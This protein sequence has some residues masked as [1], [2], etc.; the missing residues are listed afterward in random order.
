ML[1]P[2]RRNETRRLSRLRSCAHTRFEFTGETVTPIFPITPAGSPG[3]R[4]MFVHVSPP[5]VD[6]KSPLPVP[7]E[8]SFHGFRYACQNAA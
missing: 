5:S 1:R 7:P 2:R 3:L 8:T 4:V 6:L